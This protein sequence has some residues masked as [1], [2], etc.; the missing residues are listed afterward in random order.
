MMA[1][2]DYWPSVVGNLRKTRVSWAHMKRILVR[3]G[4]NPRISGIFSKAVV[5][6]V[7][8]FGSETW[9]LTPCME[10]AL[11][12]F[13]HRVARRITG[14]QPR[15]RDEGVWD[16]PSLASVIEEENFEDIGVYIQSS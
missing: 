16:Y 6:A 15:R 2:D 7:L 4:A 1:G 13:Q 9:V 5:Q 14:N 8:F 12:I 3:E 11:G 10:R